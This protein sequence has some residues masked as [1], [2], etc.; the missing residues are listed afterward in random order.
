M[1]RV[2]FSVAGPTQ[3]E[4]LVVAEAPEDVVA[5]LSAGTWAELTQDLGRGKTARVW[6]NPAAVRYVLADER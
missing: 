4:H 2:V 6:V 5:M 1:T 3:R